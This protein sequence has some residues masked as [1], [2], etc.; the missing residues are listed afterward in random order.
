[1]EGDTDMDFKLTTSAFNNDAIIP[2][3]YTCSGA[4]VSPPFEWQ[5]APEAAKGFALICE[6]SDAPGGTFHHWAIFDIPAGWHQLTEG[7]PR[8][9]TLAEGLR[10][11]VNDFGKIG[12]G[13]PC[14][15]KG[16]GT[17]HYHFQLLALDVANLGLAA[18]VDCRQVASAVR[19][20]ILAAK[21]IVGI[22]SR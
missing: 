16:H 3:R 5:G 8:A 18:R 12:Y 19:A 10:Q 17:H 9:E 21:E 14:P 11:A 6:D 13:G 15:P 22:F 7:V 2:Q 1:M 4:D 20:H